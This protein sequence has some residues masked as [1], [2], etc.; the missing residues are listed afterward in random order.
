MNEASD[1]Q[2][3]GVRRVGLA[4]GSPRRGAGRR[5]E[6]VDRHQ[7]AAGGRR[8]GARAGLL[9]A[10]GG[11]LP[12]PAVVYYPPPPVAVVPV[13]IAPIVPMVGIGVWGSSGH[14]HDGHGHWNGHGNNWNGHGKTG[15]AAAGRTATG[16]ATTGTAATGMAGA[17]TA[18]ATATGTAAATAT[19]TAA[20]SPATATATG[21]EA[22]TAAP[23]PTSAAAAGAEEPAT[24]VG[25]PGGRP[26]PPGPPDPRST[27]PEAASRRHRSTQPRRGA[28]A[29]SASLRAPRL[30]GP[31]HVANDRCRVLPRVAQRRVT[32][33]AG[34]R[35]AASHNDLR[36]RRAAPR[37][38]G[39]PHA[40]RP[41]CHHGGRGA[42]AR[43]PA[44]G[45]PSRPAR[46]ASILFTF[47]HRRDRTTLAWSDASAPAFPS[48]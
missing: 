10:A 27:V 2:E 12:A 22:A 3:P 33:T 1:P 7:P 29:P 45:H 8:D 16:T 36:G 35:I 32:S 42:D 30:V 24:S 9:P 25:R 38:T 23:S 5:R 13:P 18:T 37:S 39:A 26:G 21:T 31:R 47:L 40:G 11:L 4:G 48:E 46:G 20:A 17:G 43:D 19:G 6:L 41:P 44:S 15:T 28:C 14:D 34:L